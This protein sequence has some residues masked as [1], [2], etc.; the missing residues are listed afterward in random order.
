VAEPDRENK[1]VVEDKEKNILY[2][3]G[4]NLDE[5][6]KN[7]KNYLLE[8]GYSR[9]EAEMKVRGARFLLGEPVSNI[10]HP[11]EKDEA[12]EPLSVKC[13]CLGEILKEMKK[14]LSK[15]YGI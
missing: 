5:V 11:K 7:I 4:S 13:S 1:K 14:Y 10:Y 9:E 15:K 8:K 6:R 2:I 3:E 12:E